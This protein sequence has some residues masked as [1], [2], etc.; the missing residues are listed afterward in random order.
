MD[1]LF[2]NK[3]TAEIVN[4]KREG[5]NRGMKLKIVGAP[6]MKQKSTGK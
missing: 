2:A 5:M 1:N 6:G 3:N 4:S